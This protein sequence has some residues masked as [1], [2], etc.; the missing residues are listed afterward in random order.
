[1]IHS[2]IP[3]MIH[4]S[5]S[6]MLLPLALALSAS[7]GSPAT[8]AAEP[9]PT[10]PAP[11]AW[12]AFNAWDIGTLLSPSLHLHGIGGAS[13]THHPADL[14][15][16]GHDPSRE[17]FSAQAI[18]PSLSLHSQYLEGFANH[19]FY[20]DAGGTWQ[21]EWEEA[22]AKL[23]NLPGGLELKGGRYLP[24][25]GALNDKHLHAWDFADAELANT[26]FL[27]EHGLL[28][29]GA[30]LSWTLPLNREPYL[31]TIASLGFGNTPASGHD[32]EHDE[33]GDEAPHEGALATPSEDILTARLVARQ[34]FDDF[35]S[36][37]AGLSF[38]T[39]TNG[40]SR[41]THIA[42][43]DAEYLWRENGIEPGGRAFRLRGELLWRDVEAYSEHDEDDDGIINP[44]KG[45]EIFS[46][47]HSETGAYA[48]AIYTWNTHL[49][50]A[51][52]LGWTDG[53]SE[54]GQSGRFRISPAI[55]WWLDN[56]RRV[57]LRTQY[58]F[59]HLSGSNDEH[60]LW[61]QLNIALGSTREVR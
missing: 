46:G 49:D 43:I 15:T 29:E 18:E 58:N 4:P 59:D 45:D 3:T 50:T 55:T 11:D 34:R 27:G 60:A 52:R 57:G 9:S 38:T 7:A 24:R 17:A 41:D 56:E 28:L 22:F 13:S 10:Q 51:L 54:F 30:E 12:T 40:F 23:V 31:T 6:L 35:H 44:S 48:H 21:N 32:H 2:L 20:Q 5:H 42:G 36:L 33:H 39:G 37:T 16:G 19:I 8:P 26:T 1:M 47:T 25:L 61:F 14:A 53:T